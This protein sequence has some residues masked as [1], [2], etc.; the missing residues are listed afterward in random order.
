MAPISVGTPRRRAR[1]EALADKVLKGEQKLTTIMARATA[2]GKPTVGDLSHHATQNAA[3]APNA[4]M[5]RSSSADRGQKQG[6][7]YLLGFQNNPQKIRPLHLRPLI[8][9]PYPHKES[10]TGSTTTPKL[11]RRRPW[12]RVNDRMTI[13]GCCLVSDLERMERTM[14]LAMMNSAHPR[15][16]LKRDLLRP[17]RQTSARG[18]GL[19]GSSSP[20]RCPRSLWISRPDF[21][22]P[23]GVGLSATCRPR[24]RRG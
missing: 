10:P 14:L 8:T 20:G 21:S 24:R 4:I 13:A 22:P 7:S 23:P 1:R 12:R 19:S 15:P 17:R 11:P 6:A 16:V 3:P 9:E 2:W 18:A 5:R